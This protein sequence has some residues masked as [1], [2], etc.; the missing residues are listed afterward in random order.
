MLLL[1]ACGQC[2]SETKTGEKP[3]RAAEDKFTV[4][5]PV[6]LEINGYNYTDLYID[7]FT[8]NGQGW[9]KH[10]RQLSGIGWRRKCVLRESLAGPRITHDTDSQM[11]AGQQSLV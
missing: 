9:R 8:V 4:S 6:S 11:D 1:S 5:N 3:A 2:N 10:L 7:G